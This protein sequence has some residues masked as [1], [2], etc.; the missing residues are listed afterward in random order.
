[1]DLTVGPNFF[2]WP[3]ETV[4]AF[5]RVSMPPFLSAN[6]GARLPGSKKP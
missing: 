3:A 5:Y 2:F 4:R 6:R 1:M